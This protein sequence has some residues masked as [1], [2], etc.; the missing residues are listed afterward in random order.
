MSLTTT[1]ITSA[2]RRKI[3]EASTD[4]VAD[5]TILEYANLTYDELK[6]RTFTN[7]QVQSATVTFTSGTG[8]LPTDFGTLYSDPQVSATDTTTYPEK[9]I[10]D[11]DQ[12]PTENGVTIEG[13][14]IKVHPTTVSSLVIKYYPTYTALS[15]SQNPEINGNLHELIVYGTI[16]RVYEDLQDEVLSKYY[17]DIYEEEFK[18]KTGAISNYEEDPQ[19][20][21]EMFS[22]QNLI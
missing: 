18:K 2:V 4:I 5:A 1:A 20:G 15:T 19:R 16:Y 8:T 10:A 7:D 11:F 21:G 12:T 13:A 17:R 14:A 22:Y 9:S 3:L 6:I